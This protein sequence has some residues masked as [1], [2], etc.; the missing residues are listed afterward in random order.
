MK[1]S[2]ICIDELIVK[3][4]AA[5]V[6]S[7]EIAFLDAWLKESAENELYFEESKKLFEVIANFSYNIS[8]DVNAAW[9]KVRARIRDTG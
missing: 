8:F 3:Y 6:N 5:E 4:L 2:F 9:E 7:D 1:D